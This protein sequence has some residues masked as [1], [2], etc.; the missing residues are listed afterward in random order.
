EVRLQTWLNTYRSSST[1]GS[2]RNSLKNFFGA[3][4]DKELD[5]ISER[6]LDEYISGEKNNKDLEKVIYAFVTKEEEKGHAPKTIWARASAVKSFLS[7]H[8]LEMGS[9]F[10]KGLKRKRMKGRTDAVQEDHVP[11]NAELRRII[12]FLPTVGKALFRLMATSG[13]RIGEIMSLR[14]EDLVLEHPTLAPHVN[15]RRETT[16]SGKKR[17]G[18]M[19]PEAKEDLSKWLL[20]RVDYFETAVRRSQWKKHYTTPKDKWEGKSKNDDRL[21][22]FEPVTG[23]HMWN[24]A[25]KRAGLLIRDK[26]TNRFTLRPHALRKWFRTRLGAVLKL[27][28][29]E[30]LMGHEGYLTQAYRKYSKQDLSDFYVEHQEVLLLEIDISV[31]KLNN[32]VQ[33]QEQQLKAIAISQASRIADLEEG[34]KYLE[35][36]LTAHQAMLQVAIETSKKDMVRLEEFLKRLE[37]D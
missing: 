27:D 2:Y 16:K 26:T 19:T 32:K 15:F 8:D 23:Y 10:W 31:S 7:E 24:T 25:V 21:F 6:F 20:E 1:R 3:S 13:A 4:D 34:V 35:L 28:V 33:E 22:P 17:V 29:V 37:T 9:S 14:V 30:A 5:D 18:F 12:G 11:S 36:Q